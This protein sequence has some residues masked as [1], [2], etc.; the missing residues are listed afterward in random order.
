M[1]DKILRDK[2]KFYRNLSPDVEFNAIV[3]FVVL[4]KVVAEVVVVIVV[5]AENKLLRVRLVFFYN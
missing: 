3:V 2:L 5:V 4:V 1:K